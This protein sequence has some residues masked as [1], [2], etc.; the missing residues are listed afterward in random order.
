MQQLIDNQDKYNA[1]QVSDDYLA[2]HAPKP[3]TDVKKEISDVALSM[4]DTTMTKHKSQ[5]FNTFTLEGTYTGSVTKG[6]SEDWKA[7]SKKI[8]ESLEQLTQKEWS[9]YKT[10]TAYFVNYRVNAP[11]NLNMM[12]YSMVLQKDEEENKDSEV[13]INGPYNGL[14]K[15]KFNFIVMVS[16]DTDGKIVSYSGILGM[17]QQVQKQIQYMHMEKKEHIK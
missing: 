8:N 12:L 10:V 15:E 5:F 7:M 11:I 13:N 14:V 17:V 4:K 16:K 6:E 9:G 1:P 2:E 3:L